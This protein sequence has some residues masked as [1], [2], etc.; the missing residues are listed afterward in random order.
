MCWLKK[1]VYNNWMSSY[2][3]LANMFIWCYAIPSFLVL[4]NSQSRSDLDLAFSSGHEG[5]AVMT[6]SDI[7]I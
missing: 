6:E 2:L 3:Q 4:K 1:K 7:I 5:Y